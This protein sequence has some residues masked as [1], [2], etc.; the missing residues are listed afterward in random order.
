MAPQIQLKGGQYV[1]PPVNPSD[2]RTILLP[3]DGRDGYAF[4]VCV[5]TVKRPTPD[6]NLACRMIEEHVERLANGFGEG[7]HQQHRFEQFLSALNESLAEVVR[8]TEWKLPIASLHAVVGIACDNEMYLSGT[9]D[10]TALFLHRTPSQRYQV[11]NL[12]RGIRTEQ[13]LPTWEKPFAVILDGDLHP[14]DVFCLASKDL[15]PVIDNDELCAILAALPPIGAAAK[16]RQYF[17]HAAALSILVLRLQ[18]EETAA[19]EQA[20]P[21]SEVS[22]EALAENRRETERLLEDESPHPTAIFGMV[23]RLWEDKK[24]DPTMPK[25][26]AGFFEL[27]A[28]GWRGFVGRLKSIGHGAKS[29]GKREGRAEIVRQTRERTDRVLVRQ[30][31]R[32]KQLPK[33]SRYLALGAVVLLLLIVGSVS[34]LSK[35]QA[36]KEADAQYAQA[37]SQ[38]EDLRE[39]ASAAA[40]YRDEDRARS[41]YQDALDRLAKLPTD[42]P[43]RV[44]AQ[45]ALAGD[46]RSALD[47]LSHVIHLPEPPVIATFDAKASAMTF[48]GPDIY[49]FLSDKR[50]MRV[51][52]VAKTATAVPVPATSTGIAQAATTD[53]TQAV[54]VDDRPGVSIFDKDTSQLQAVSL[55]PDAGSAWRDLV[56]YNGRLYVLQ[57]DATDG[58]VLRI[59]KAGS[60]YGAGSSWIKSKTS[61]L[62]LAVGLAVDGNVYVLKSDGTVSRFEN[63]GEAGWT[64]GA[65]DPPLTQ[66]TAIW[67]DLNSNFV[68]VLDAAGRRIVVFNKDSGAYVTEYESDPFATATRLLVDEKNKTIYVLTPNT[69]YGFTAS[70]LP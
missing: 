26:R 30:L 3:L 23:K 20:R 35:G 9:G 58:G 28:E 18:G 12:S 41:L 24:T 5:F 47:T 33:S 16:I 22:L 65:V 70:H 8:T 48:I 45:N 34:V 4:A 60:S 32:L 11:F 50:V 44:S 15:A 49:A 59:P 25:R 68:Y 54:V 2:P 39:Q 38:V 51:D 67:T 7:A 19:V 64:P 1:D 10:L 43:E 69:L 17:P 62:K 27:A 37:F 14:G 31:S 57:T 61:N 56:A 42:K 6:A 66:G 52:V 53:G 46:I 29:L 21:R 63:G 13:A 55:A 40:I 36:S